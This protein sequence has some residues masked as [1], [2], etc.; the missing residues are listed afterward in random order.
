MGKISRNDRCPCGSNLKYKK[1]CLKANKDNT[2]IQ[3]FHSK[4]ER[5]GKLAQNPGKQD[6]ILDLPFGEVKM[7]E[8]I[9]EFAGDLYGRQ[10]QMLQYI[11]S[12]V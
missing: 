10:R 5:G 4:K 9:I 6:I 11:Q 8:I 3:N 1:C 7:S 2:S 12:L